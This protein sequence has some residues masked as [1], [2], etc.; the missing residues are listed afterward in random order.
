MR[1][2]II[3]ILFLLVSVTEMTFANES[4]SFDD[5][6]SQCTDISACDTIDNHS[7]IGVFS[8]RTCLEK[9]VAGSLLK[10]SEEEEK[11]RYV[12]VK[13]WQTEDCK[14]IIVYA[15]CD[16]SFKILLNTFSPNGTLREKRVIGIIDDVAVSKVIIYRED[17]IVKR[18]GWNGGKKL[19][20]NSI[21]TPTHGCNIQ[22]EGNGN[23]SWINN[24]YI[25]SSDGDINFAY[26]ANFGYIGLNVEGEKCCDIRCNDKKCAK[27]KSEEKLSDEDFLNSFPHSWTDFMGKYKYREDWSDSKMFFNLQRHLKKLLHMSN[28]YGDSVA[29]LLIQLSQDYKSDR[30]F[31]AAN[32]NTETYQLSLRDYDISHINEN[33]ISYKTLVRNMLV[34]KTDVFL[35]VLEKCTKE[36]QRNFWQFFF[37]SETKPS[38]MNYYPAIK[39]YVKK[40][41]SKKIAKIMNTVYKEKWK[42]SENIL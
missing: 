35:S 27:G 22:G 13:R 9:T 26:Q 10:L 30:T 31:Y 2:K 37:T 6:W 25:V 42:N 15:E 20:L 33:C 8:D 11:S 21:M 38:S 5:V 36:E 3:I 34:N 24:Y 19:D 29:E 16:K 40:H 4:K 41:C 18:V 32:D 28:R 23:S 12:P 1:N 14:V 7:V 39:Q 17:G